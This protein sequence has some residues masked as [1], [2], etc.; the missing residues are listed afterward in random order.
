M[1]LALVIENNLPQAMYNKKILD[2]AHFAQFSNYKIPDAPVYCTSL[3]R[4]HSKYANVSGG[5]PKSEIVTVPDYQP[6][7]VYRFDFLQQ[8]ECLF[9][10]AVALC[11]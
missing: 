9:S 7:H 3:G 11:H 6:I 4:M 5:F 10:D 1:L 2:W 8:A